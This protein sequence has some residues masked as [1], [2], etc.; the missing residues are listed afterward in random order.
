MGAWGLALAPVADPW[1]LPLVLG[2]PLAGITG[3]WVWGILK[4]ASRRARFSLQTA[5]AVLTLCACWLGWE[6]YVVQKRKALLQL[7]RESGHG[8]YDEMATEPDCGMMGLPRRAMRR[9]VG[10]RPIREIHCGED[11][12][13]EYRYWFPEAYVADGRG[14]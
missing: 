7:I 6:H 3:F 14:R 5:L 12:G 8:F 10:D 9:A 4:H 2:G 13:D 1:C 11:V